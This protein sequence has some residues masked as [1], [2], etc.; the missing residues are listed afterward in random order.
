VQPEELA[1]LKQ[2]LAEREVLLANMRFWTNAQICES[3]RS[4]KAQ[5]APKDFVWQGLTKVRMKKSEVGD[6]R[7]LEEI[8]SRIV[9]EEVDIDED[10]RESPGREVSSDQSSEGKEQVDDWSDESDTADSIEGQ[11]MINECWQ[12]T[13]KM[14]VDDA[15]Y[16]LEPAKFDE[17]DVSLIGVL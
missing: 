13:N 16:L 6:H 14:E 4:R 11:N 3:F 5:L 9:E 2:F 12:E 17:A 8:I 15:H 1:V 7:Q 10:S